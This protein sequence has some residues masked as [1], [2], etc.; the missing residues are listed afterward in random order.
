[1]A[2]LTNQQI[3][4]IQTALDHY[5]KKLSILPDKDEFSDLLST[6]KSD[7]STNSTQ[8]TEIKSMVEDKNKEY[9]EFP[10]EKRKIICL[11]LSCYIN[12]LEEHKKRILQEMCNIDISFSETDVVIRDSKDLRCKICPK[13]WIWELKSDNQ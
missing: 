1:M 3:Q 2:V 5:S 13:D 11:A 6:L 8:T 12:D 10:K 4:T 9:E 7:L